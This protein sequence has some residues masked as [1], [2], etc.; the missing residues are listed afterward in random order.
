MQKQNRMKRIGASPQKKRASGSRGPDQELSGVPALRVLLLFCFVVAIS[1]SAVGCAV[2]IVNRTATS[3]QGALFT[4]NLGGESAQNEHTRGQQPDN[5]TEHDSTVLNRPVADSVTS[6]P[7]VEQTPSVTTANREQILA[8]LGQERAIIHHLEHG[9]EYTLPL[10]LLLDYGEQLFAASWT[11]QDG[12][13]RP[14]T[15][16]TGVPLSDQSKPLVFPNNFNRIS[17]PDANACSGCHNMPFGVPGGGGDI[18]TNVFVLGQRFDFATF[19]PGDTVPLRGATDETGE[20]VTLQTIANSRATPG[21]FGS[22]YIEMLARQMTADLQAIRNT[23]EPG[24]TRP[25]TTKGIDFGMLSR[26][27]DGTWN[28]SAVEGLIP[29]SVTSAG[30]LDPP[31]L[32]IC[33]FHQASSVIS[34]RQFTNNA[35]NHHHGIQ[36]AERFGHEIDADADGMVNELTI[37]DMTAVTLYQA[38]MAVPGRV[39]PRE[40]LIAEAIWTGEQLFD[41]IGCTSCHVT[42]LPLVDEG[43][44]YTEPNPFNPEQELQVGDIP[45]YRMDLSSV[46]LPLPRL[47]PVDNVVMV[48]AYTDLKVHDITSG[49]YDPN[50]EVLDMQ[51][52]GTGAALSSGNRSFITRRLWGVA[53]EPPY[54]HHGLF[55][56]LRQAVEAHAGEALASRQA[57]ADLSE[58]EQNAVIEFLK[59][60]QVL[61]PGTP[62]LYV[63]EFGD[64]VEWPPAGM[65]AVRP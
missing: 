59:S 21:L 56:T 43:W 26:N 23:L 47:Q 10:S 3:R 14:L 53:N 40:P 58:Y 61:P 46:D 39:I 6:M 45:T 33:P 48:P 65:V 20:M 27:A 55:T 18:V 8:T 1:L 34:L 42:A 2:Q 60:L 54:F 16:G 9:E 52:A 49:G 24:D 12:A 51:K 15:K 13:G 30:P 36:S 11:V 41:Q 37:A 17:G 62:Y 4:I 44:I 25:L 29:G 57:Y 63:D 28:T 19:D 50:V 35:F 7:S 31:T 64:P 22:G 5:T 32:A 38:A